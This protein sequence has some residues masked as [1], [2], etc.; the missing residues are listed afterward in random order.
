LLNSLT[1]SLD[2][3]AYQMKYRIDDGP[4]PLAHGAFREYVGVVRLLSVRDTNQTFIEWRSQYSGG[5]DDAITE[6]CDPV[7]ANVVR[8]LK[9]KF[10]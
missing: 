3:H 5:N 4:G 2:E 10:A 7:Y 9:T 1:S 6:L 8:A